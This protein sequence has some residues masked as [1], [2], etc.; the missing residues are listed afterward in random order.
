MRQD[1]ELIKQ[2]ADDVHLYTKTVLGRSGIVSE[3]KADEIAR[4]IRLTLKD[5]LSDVT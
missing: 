4:I 3:K 5:E 2:L 1:N